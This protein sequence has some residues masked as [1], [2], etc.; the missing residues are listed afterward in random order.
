MITRPYVV[1]Q[2][3]NVQ[4]LLHDVTVPIRSLGN[5][6][7]NREPFRS[8]RIEEGQRIHRATL[9][10]DEASAALG[11][12][13]ASAA[14]SVIAITC[15]EASQHNCHRDFVIDELTKHEALPVRSI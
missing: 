14:R 12:L 5:H 15:F 9:A 7:D 2:A 8:G 3:N 6:K 10:S 11:E 4:F 13:S 1:T